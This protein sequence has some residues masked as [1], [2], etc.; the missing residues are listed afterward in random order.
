MLEYN[1]CGVPACLKFF[2]SIFVYGF[3]CVLFAGYCGMGSVG[4]LLTVKPPI[5]SADVREASRDGT[6]LVESVTVKGTSS[7]FVLKLNR[8][9]YD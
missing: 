4:C 5:S 3:Q 1:R 7:S 8:G 6:Q 2:L 9:V